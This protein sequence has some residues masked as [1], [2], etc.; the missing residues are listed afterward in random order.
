MNERSELTLE[1]IQQK[2][3]PYG[4]GEAQAMIRVT[5]AASDESAGPPTASGAEVIIVDC[6]GSMAHPRP[7]LLASCWTWARIPPRSASANAAWL[8]FES[9]IG[10]Q[11]T[12]GPILCGQNPRSDAVMR[13]LLG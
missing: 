4:A 3:L 10:R 11:F 7:K 1:I 6:S 13:R 9:M 8:A 5:A 12:R 2:Y